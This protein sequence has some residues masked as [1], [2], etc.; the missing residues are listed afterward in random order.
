MGSGELLDGSP[1]GYRSRNVLKSSVF[2]DEKGVRGSEKSRIVCLP[3]LKRRVHAVALTS[4]SFGY[5]AR[6]VW[7]NSR[8]E[9]SSPSC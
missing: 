7:C 1:D 9:R 5:R 6:S 8:M 4:S 2:S 3:C